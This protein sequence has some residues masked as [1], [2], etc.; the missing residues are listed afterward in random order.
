MFVRRVIS[1]DLGY[2]ENYLYSHNY[3]KH[4]VKQQ[5]LPDNARGQCFWE[6]DEGNKAEALMKLRQ[7]DR[8]GE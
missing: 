3:P 4:F 1:L 5:Y 7:K 6:A 8:W 2:G